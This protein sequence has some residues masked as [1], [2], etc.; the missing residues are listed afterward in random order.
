MNIAVTGEGII[1]AIGFN[2]QEV[3]RSL[4]AGESGI[5]EAKASS[6]SSS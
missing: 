5:G 2:K 6:I 4:I 1:S 3:L